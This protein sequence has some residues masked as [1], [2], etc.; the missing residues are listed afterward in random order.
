MPTINGKRVLASSPEAQALLNSRGGIKKTPNTLEPAVSANDMANPT[1][2]VNP[3]IPKVN[4]N[5]GSQLNSLIGNVATNNQ[6]FITAQSEEAAKAKELAGLLGTQ[7][8]DGA[9]QREALGEQYGLPA[10]LSR[11]TD[12]QTQLTQANTAS[13]VTKTQIEGAAGQTMAQAQREVTQEDRENAVRTAGLAAEAAVLQGAVETASTLIDQ[14]MSD[15]YQDR[16]LQNQNMITQ[17]NYYSGIVDEQ[18]KQLVDQETRKYE[19]DLLE[20]QDA[21]TTVNAAVATGLASANDIA[22]MTALSGNPAK[23]QE[24]ANQII[25]KAARQD[26]ALRQAEINA[27]LADKGVK[28]PELQNFGTSDKPIWRQWNADLGTWEDVS[29][30]DSAS[31]QKDNLATITEH[32]IEANR[33]IDSILSKPLGIKATT[34]I[35]QGGI[36]TGVE[37]ATTQPW[38]VAPTSALISGVQAANERMDLL[39]DLS[40]LVNDATF[41]EMR[42]LKESGVTFGALT[43]GERKAIGRASD[44]L[45]SALKVDDSGMVTGINTTEDKFYSLVND[46]QQKLIQYQDEANKMSAG[47]NQADADLIESQ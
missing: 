29:G 25:A 23:Q 2:T 15:F 26:L 8:F 42:S 1:P 14:A 31:L 41:S 16:I 28:A 36:G 38:Q 30:V 47:L 6:N 4:T 34:G 45:F 33:A 46:Y 13:G 21:K 22:T 44:A 7:T 19:A 3:P 27:R 18:T 40:F 43:E 35:I 39:S 24:Y 20:I 37:A 17:L 10:N 32:T 12:I 9:G 11:L 5:D